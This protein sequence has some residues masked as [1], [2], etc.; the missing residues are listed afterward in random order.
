MLP[1][2][3]HHL[4]TSKYSHVI[5]PIDYKPQKIPKLDWIGVGSF[6]TLIDGESN[7]LLDV[8]GH[9]M[10]FDC[11]MSFKHMITPQQLRDIEAVYISHLHS[12]HAGG[13]EFLLYACYYQLQKRITL[14]A[15]FEVISEL[16]NMFHGNLGKTSFGD[17]GLEFYCDILTIE[18]CVDETVSRDNYRRG[19]SFYGVDIS[20]IRLPHVIPHAYTLTN[21]DLTQCMLSYGLLFRYNDY[22]VFWS[23]DCTESDACSDMA[24]I[25]IKA[26]EMADLVFHEC[27]DSDFVSGVHANLKVHLMQYPKNIR[28]KMYLYHMSDRRPRDEAIKALGFAGAVQKRQVFELQ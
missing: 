28:T 13:L 24:N 15:P 21:R 17:Q 5:G 19:A 18:H 10:V 25:K 6:F 27:E 26:M 3:Q 1:H 14:V 11:G 4:S 16:R 7:F 2:E 20:C 23:S 22:F 12:D 9:L 8:D